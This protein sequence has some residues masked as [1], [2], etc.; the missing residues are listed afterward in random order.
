MASDLGH[1]HLAPR[2]L[3]QQIPPSKRDHLRFK[4]PIRKMSSRVFVAPTG[5]SAA[6]KIGTSIVD[7]HFKCCSLPLAMSIASKTRFRLGGPIRNRRFEPPLNPE[8]LCA[9]N[10][11]SVA[12]KWPPA[13]VAIANSHGESSRGAKGA[14]EP[15]ETGN[16]WPS[17]IPVQSPPTLT[18]K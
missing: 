9:A 15:R 10:K 12:R 2:K 17:C 6:I 1:A 16:N 4:G 8:G 7:C 11:V 5:R 3:V 14:R 13:F 18:W